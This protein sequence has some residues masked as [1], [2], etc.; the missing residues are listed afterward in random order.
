[1]RKKQRKLVITFESTVAAMAAEKY[2][3]EQNVSGRLIPVPTQITAGCGLAWAANP[4]ARER[5]LSVLKQ[6]AINPEGIYEI[7][8]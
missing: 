3:K 4:E 8:I 6:N 7:I 1:M 5:V 2:C